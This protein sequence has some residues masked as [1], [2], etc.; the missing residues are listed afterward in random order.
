MRKKR[1]YKTIFQSQF[2]R[3]VTS[4]GTK[5]EANVAAKVIRNS[6]KSLKLSKGTQVWVEPESK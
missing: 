1:R 2:S 4:Y 6:L 5:R 3:A